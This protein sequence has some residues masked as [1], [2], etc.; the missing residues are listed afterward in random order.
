M[1][2]VVPPRVVI[3]GGLSG[4]LCVQRGTHGAFL[5]VGQMLE[6]LYQELLNDR[7]KRIGT[8]GGGPDSE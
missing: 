3:G 1:L 4:R 6:N 5:E 8:S 2:K 7:Y